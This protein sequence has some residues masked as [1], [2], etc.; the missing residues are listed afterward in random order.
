M[1]DTKELPPL[2]PGTHP[3]QSM[4]KI[5]EESGAIA[6]AARRNASTLA[7]WQIKSKYRFF[8]A[9]RSGIDPTNR[10]KW[11]PRVPFQSYV[12]NNSLSGPL[13]VGRGLVRYVAALDFEVAV[14]IW[15]GECYLGS[16][17]L[18]RKYRWLPVHIHISLGWRGKK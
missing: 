15:A 4:T 13:R 7:F 6:A 3:V 10:P 16:T 1:A 14:G 11:Q 12:G 18:T 8:I 2:P 17:K 5:R 9:W